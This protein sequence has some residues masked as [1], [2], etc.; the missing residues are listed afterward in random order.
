MGI[1]SFLRSMYQ[2][3]HHTAHIRLLITLRIQLRI[4]ELHGIRVIP[5]FGGIELYD[6]VIIRHR[7]PVCSFAASCGLLSICDRYCSQFDDTVS[8][9][10]RSS[11]FIFH[12]PFFVFSVL[13]T[14][15]GLLCLHHRLLEPYRP[16]SVYLIN[17][18]P[19]S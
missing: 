16:F 2:T 13:R 4:R 3:A 14:L 18:R 5:R 6:D 9:F 7:R 12:F 8:R 10:L 19:S 1:F 17:T 11:F 15:M